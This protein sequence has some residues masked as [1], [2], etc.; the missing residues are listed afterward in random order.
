MVDT[1]ESGGNRNGRGSCD[2]TKELLESR[3]S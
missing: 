3:H 1:V 2:G